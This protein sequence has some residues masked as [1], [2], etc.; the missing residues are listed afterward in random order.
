MAFFGDDYL[1]D[2]H[3]TYEFDLTLQA[4]GSKARWYAI[5][6]VEEMSKMFNESSPLYQKY[7]SGIPHDEEFWGPS[8]FVD[9]VYKYKIVRNGIVR[10]YFVNEMSKVACYAVP[11]MSSLKWMLGEE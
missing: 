4:S 5:T 7:Q 10:N 9:D 11:S 8:F 1:S 6:V 3:A 2:I